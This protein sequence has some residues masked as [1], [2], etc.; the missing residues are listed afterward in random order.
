M[1]IETVRVH[2]KLTVPDDA[3][4]GLSWDVDYYT[5]NR[6]GDWWSM[7]VTAHPVW[8][9]MDLQGWS[10][11]GSRQETVRI[12]IRV[13]FEVISPLRAER[14]LVE[15]TVHDYVM[16]TALPPI[17]QEIRERLLGLAGRATQEIYDREAEQ[18]RHLRE[19][20]AA[21]Y[22]KSA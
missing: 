19:Q 3:V 8:G 11:H 12:P 1:E 16:A 21:H 5:V 22:K 18:F 4:P 13:G 20:L 2:K 7:Y 14:R 10:G 15:D 9:E 17:L 6:N